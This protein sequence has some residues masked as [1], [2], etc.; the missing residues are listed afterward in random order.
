MKRLAGLGTLLLLLLTGCSV[1]VPEMPDIDLPFA[2]DKSETD[3][4]APDSDTDEPNPE[5]TLT[6]GDAIIPAQTEA[7]AADSETDV[8]AL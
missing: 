5:A 2:G 4:A 1:E 6:T 8:R 3:T 7:P